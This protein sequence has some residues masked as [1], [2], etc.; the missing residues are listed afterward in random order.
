MTSRPETPDA[1]TCSADCSSASS[2]ETLNRTCYCLSLDESALHASLEN[3][4]GVSDLPSAVVETHPHLFASLPVFIAPHHLEQM[5]QLVEAVEQ[6][7]ASPVFQRAA[8]S[9]APPIARF[10]PGPRGGLLGYD[11]HLTDAGTQLI[12][13]NTNPGGAFLNAVL[14]RAQR[15]CC[16]GAAGLAIAPRDTA[17]VEQALL[18][19][20]EKEWRLQ[21]ET[22]ALRTIA[23]VDDAPERQYLYPEFLLVR[24]LL[25]RRGIDAI[26]CDPSDL[27]TSGGRI[28]YRGTPIDLI[29][30]RLT[31]FSLQLPAHDSIKLA[32][33]AGDV[34]L[35]PHPRAHALYADKRNLTLLS[36]SSFLHST[37]VPD[38]VVATLL[39]SIPH[40]ELLTAENRDAMW[41]DRRRLFFKPA[42]GYGSKATYRGDKLTKRVWEEIA[43]G[44]YV[45]QSLVVPSE[46]QIVDAAGPATLKVDVRNYAYDGTVKLVAARLYQGQTTNFRTAGG[47]FAPVLTSRDGRRDS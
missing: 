29:Y 40:T 41:R 30:N 23:I 39:N 18:D 37:D 46:R 33:L 15:A 22:L 36:D 16:T 6:V 43:G 10:D 27:I 5:T 17:D 8:L 13:I 31:D 3:E 11:F 9:W 7:V 44:T 35:T 4:L 14:A 26:I 38:E 32:Y 2:A 21:R 47:G 25:K 12:E 19:V 42:A 24:Q 28:S 45:A 20:F 1:T 34:V